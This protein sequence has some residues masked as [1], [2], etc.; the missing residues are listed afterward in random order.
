MIMLSKHY[1]NEINSLLL[2]EKEQAQER[3]KKR[4]GKKEGTREE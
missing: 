1:D 2:L 3:E 4:E